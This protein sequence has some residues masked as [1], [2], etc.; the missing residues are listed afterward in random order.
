MTQSYFGYRIR[1][2]GA[3]VAIPF[4]WI[5]QLFGLIGALFVALIGGLVDWFLEWFPVSLVMLVLACV[6]ILVVAGIVRFKPNPP[7]ALAVEAPADLQPAPAPVDPK[8][9]VLLMKV[10]RTGVRGIAII[11]DQQSGC[12]YLVLQGRPPV[13]RTF[14]DQSGGSRQWCV[15]AP[16]AQNAEVPANQRDVD[17]GWF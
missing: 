13:P 16:Y 14:W 6:A 12:E 4:R 8:G 7:A 15:D 17:A 11:Q 1:K 2:I 3:V 9:P 10:I 5:G